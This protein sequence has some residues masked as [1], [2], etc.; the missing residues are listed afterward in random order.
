[1]TTEEASEYAKQLWQ[2]FSPRLAPLVEV[3]QPQDMHDRFK[4]FFD[5]LDLG[6]LY[7]I[8]E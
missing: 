6:G 2:R 1:M 7:P 8:P 5:N 3:E 4:L